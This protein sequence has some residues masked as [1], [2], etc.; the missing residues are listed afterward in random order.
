MSNPNDF[1]T[2]VIEEFRANGGKVKVPQGPGLGCDPDPALLARYAKGEVTRTV[3]GGRSSR[4]HLSNSGP[5][6][7]TLRGR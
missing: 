2:K 1:N 3:M 4:S 5:L 6:S 7:S